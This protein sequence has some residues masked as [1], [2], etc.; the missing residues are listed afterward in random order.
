MKK[1]LTKY[2]LNEFKIAMAILKQPDCSYPL[3]Q[4]KLYTIAEMLGLDD[5]YSLD[6]ED[7]LNMEI[8]ISPPSQQEL[9]VSHAMQL[10]GTNKWEGFRELVLDG[11]IKR[12]AFIEIIE[13]GL[14]KIVLKHQYKVDEI[15]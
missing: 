5:S 4:N 1:I 8:M 10:I 15:S 9:W 14:D 2:Q 7:L 13:L 11:L 6:D 3:I 12:N